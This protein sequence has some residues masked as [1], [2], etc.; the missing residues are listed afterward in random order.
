MKKIFLTFLVLLFFGVNIYAVN[1]GF[2]YYGP[3]AK[4]VSVSGS[5][6]NWSKTS[7][8][9]AFSDSDGYWRTTL[10]LNSGSRYEYKFI[11]NGNDWFT[12]PLNP[13]VDYGNHDN[14]V[15]LVSDSSRAA[16]KPTAP[17]SKIKQFLKGSDISFLDE[18][19]EK[20]AKYYANGRHI[21]VLR[22]FKENG[23]NIVRLRLWYKPK[24]GYCDLSRTLKMAVRAKKD[25]LRVL[26]DLHYS[27]SWADPGH[28][29]K[30]AAWA[31]LKG[32]AL[33]QA[34]YEYTFN[35][36]RKF[37][38]E[39]VMPYIVQIGNEIDGGFLWPDG[40][41]N[42][43]KNQ[44]HKV[45][46]FIRLLN[47]AIKG[48]RDNFS[49]GANSLIMIHISRSGSND[50]Y[51]RYL[52]MLLK[53]NVKFDVIGLSYYPWWDGGLESFRM[54]VNNLALRYGKD[55]IIVETAYPWT[56]KG[57]DN[58]GNIISSREKLL[59]GYPATPAGQKAFI[60]KVLTIV[61]NV[62]F[63]LGR[64]VLYWAPEDISIGAKPS[65]WENMTFFN[66]AGA[67]LPVSKVF[68]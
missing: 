33:R 52:D 1:V 51:L 23:Q 5:F 27:D 36:I 34:V 57:N 35:V 13:D 4:S 2:R 50:F 58:N 21:D 60:Q 32:A 10:T 31:T 61:K 24:D 25:G 67:A 43:Y 49:A 53:H 38:E 11:V 12:D 54:N 17:H 59:N 45:N 68:R 30:P 46:N 47:A 26:L 39:G 3:F 29:K 18:L 56:L 62:P 6:N 7:G 14:S 63:S 42:V 44:P 15:L 28:Q 19:E 40:R 55:I 41:I 37:K 20:G 8:S 22:F 48:V 9:M 65:V 16:F 64:G 66:F